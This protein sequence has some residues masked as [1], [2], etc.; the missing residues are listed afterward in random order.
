MS[1]NKSS[2]LT[3]RQLDLITRAHCD[4]GGLIEPLL[5]LK[6]GAKLKMIASLAQRGLIEQR[7]DQWRITPAAIAIVQGKTPAKD[8][9]PTADAVSATPTALVDDPEIEAIVSAAEASWQAVQAKTTDRLTKLEASQTREG[10]KQA[11]VIEMLKRPEGATI[12]QISEVTGW[13]KHTIRGT[14]SGTLKKK[15]GL[16]IVSEKMTGPADAPGAGQR[17]Y[18]ITEAVAA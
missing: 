1:T 12:E 2:A 13:Q 17:L 15:L 3:E 7:D 10:S 5:K 18:R 11:L 9:L 6:G 14:F 8:D 16:T 4:T